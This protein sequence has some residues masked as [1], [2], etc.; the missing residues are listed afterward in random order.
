MKSSKSK[1]NVNQ[2]KNKSDEV[3]QVSAPLQSVVDHQSQ[4]D[5]DFLPDDGACKSQKEEICQKM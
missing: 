2:E 5:I 3:V 1:R 4:K